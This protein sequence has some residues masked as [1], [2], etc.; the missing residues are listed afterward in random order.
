MFDKICLE[1]RQSDYPDINFRTIIFQRFKYVTKGKSIIVYIKSPNPNGSNDAKITV[2]SDRMKI[3][4]SPWKWYKGFNLEPFTYRDLITA[5]EMIQDKIGIPLNK[6]TLKWLEIAVNMQ[7]ENPP[8][9]YYEYL[10]ELK[11]Y[12][13]R[14]PTVAI[15][16]KKHFTI[17][18]RQYI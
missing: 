18:R 4:F 5:T 7:M 17:Q 14:K 8:F 6:F 10:D 9:V 11:P 15:L 2:T 1:A 16:K 13:E 12:P 3:E